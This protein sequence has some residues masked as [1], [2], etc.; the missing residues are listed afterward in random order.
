[1]AEFQLANLGPGSMHGFLPLS[2][3]FLQFDNLNSISG[4]LGIRPHPSIDIDRFVDP[5]DH[6][7][8]QN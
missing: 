3:C 1:V 4:A 8:K 6:L 5:E 7:K 2:L